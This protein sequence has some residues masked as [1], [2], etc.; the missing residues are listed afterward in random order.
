MT[1]GQWLS[2]VWLLLT[3][4]CSLHS[5][6]VC[7][8][9]RYSQEGNKEIHKRDLSKMFPIRL[10][11]GSKSCEGRLEIFYNETW[12]TVCDD[13]WDMVDAGMVC[14]QLQCGK[15]VPWLTG[16]FYGGGTGPILM[17]NVECQGLETEL[18]LCSHAGWGVHNCS[19]HEDVGVQ[20]EEITFGGKDFG[21][22]T[23]PWPTIVAPEASNGDLR[24]VNGAHRCQGRVEIFY[25]GAWG[26]VCDDDWSMNNA[27]VVCWQL[28][29]GNAVSYHREA[30][31]DRG[32]GEI[33]LD[34]VN[35][36]GNEV[37][38]QGC[39]HLEWTI[40]NCGHHEDAGVTCEL[41]ST[42][43]PNEDRTTFATG[44]SDANRILP[45]TTRTV[46]PATTKAVPSTT[47]ATTAR[48][49]API[50]LVNGGHRCEGRL[51]IFF[52]NS[53]GTVCDDGW[54]MIN[55]MV[56]CR[57]LQC[58]KALN[59]SIR[60]YFGAGI[61]PI[62][63]DNVDCFGHEQGVSSCPHLGVGQHNCNHNEDAGVICKSSD[64]S[65]QFAEIA[66]NLAMPGVLIPKRE[67]TASTIQPPSGTL[68]LVGGNHS[69]EGR[70]EVFLQYEWGTVCDDAWDLPDA[71]V[72]CRQLGCGQAVEAVPQARFGPGTGTIQLDNLK[73][74]G[75][76]GLLLKCS[77]IPW[78]AH[79]CDHSEDAGV[80][81]QI[82]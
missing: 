74:M 14:R 30:F 60:A 40:H 48:G 18:G 8:V 82:L 62:W 9:L 50:R 33:H 37:E 73:C 4:L 41:P 15:P 32:T 39:S 35:C 49:P 23:T 44:I 54:N 52:S 78:N 55:A 69:C 20:C 53:W 64:A 56:V 21:D 34:N 58:G 68:R 28:N 16:P 65:I 46:A 45:V 12:G 81:C 5:V 42:V 70:V 3:L 25:N 79:N 67:T 61:G 66:Q 47:V 63:L 13:N 80:V 29:C 38:L 17:D 59:A 19:H 22:F 43:Q 2:G 10:V 36:N 57:Q 27:R 6:G 24:L 31:F 7:S 77:Y 51:E 75:S 11:N 71:Q 76:E 72:V 26:T 1:A